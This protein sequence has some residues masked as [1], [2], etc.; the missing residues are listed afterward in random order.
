MQVKKF[1]A[2]TIQ[3]ALDVIK[4]E[5]GPEAIILKTRQNKRGFGLLAGGSFEVTAAVSERALQKKQVVT[6]RIPEMS[7]EAIEKLPASRQQE[8]YEKYIDKKRQANRARGGARTE[9]E[10]P[11]KRMTATRY[12]D[13]DE[14][15]RTSFESPPMVQAPVASRQ[16]LSQSRSLQDEVNL[17][18]RMIEEMK[19]EQHGRQDAEVQGYLK[20]S[21]AFTPEIQEALEQ[22]II[23]GVDKRFALS[24]IKQVT[25]NLMRVSDPDS[26]A[27]LDQ[28]A[29]EIM[30]STE[31]ISLLTGIHP[32]TPGDRGAP[33]LKIALVGPTGVG[34]TTTLAK[35]AS[36]A[37]L[38]RGLKVG[39]IN[40]DCY[41]VAAFDQLGTYAKILKVPYRQVSTEEDLD[42]ALKDFKNLDLVLIDTTGRS[43]RDIESLQEMKGM[44]SRVGDIRTELVLSVT[45]RDSELY[46][47]G[48]KF[49]KV[50]RPDGLI[51]SKLDEGIIYGA[52]FNL[53]QKL[54]LPLVYFT[55]GQRVP[56]DIE[57][58]SRERVAS[59]I[60]DLQ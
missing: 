32:R 56:E 44:L 46:D 17:L 59:L 4:Q 35:I 21:R 28:V 42:L 11:R 7:R 22:L 37:T 13:I 31:V 24:L 19:T 34:K 3:E 2:P 47:M 30:E 9:G 5:L 27:I 51:L 25:F 26:E 36:E 39:V 1:E 55:T 20:N 53:C 38:T 18:K 14:D 23:N 12:I 43:Q 6:S 52:I 33:P 8:I 15:Q 49:Q 48:S 58:A 10:A 16:E 50:F 60:M 45:T 40:I 54:K 41:R 57:E 29:M